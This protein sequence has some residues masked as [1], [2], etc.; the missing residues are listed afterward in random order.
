MYSENIFIF[1]PHEFNVDNTKDVTS[2][3]NKV[4]EELSD[5][6]DDEIIL[7]DMQT[8]HEL[9]EFIYDNIFNKSKELKVNINKDIEGTDKSFP[10]PEHQERQTHLVV[11]QKSMLKK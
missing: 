1:N 7:D 9:N 4:S 3:Y 2:Y 8:N 6:I 11:Q 5:E 10:T